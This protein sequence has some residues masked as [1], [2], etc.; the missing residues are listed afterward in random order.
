MST[1][2]IIQAEKPKAFANWREHPIEVKL[3]DFSVLAW[4]AI[5]IL[6]VIFYFAKITITIRIFPAVMLPFFMFI[7]TFVLRLQLVEKPAM[8]R[9]IFAIWVS[10]F[11]FFILLSALVLAFYPPLIR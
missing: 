8:V 3:M 11:I 1:E 10:L 7:I 5:M 9:K 6:D 2:E 4:L